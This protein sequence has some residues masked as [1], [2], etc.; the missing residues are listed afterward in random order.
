MRPTICF[1]PHCDI[2]IYENLL[3]AN[4]SKEKLSNILLV[5]NRL[6]DYLDRSPLLLIYRT[7]W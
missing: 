7:T 1:M 6:A 5:A 3:Q 2:D 4:C